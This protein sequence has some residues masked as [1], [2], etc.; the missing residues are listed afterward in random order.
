MPKASFKKT[1]TMDESTVT[2]KEPTPTPTVNINTETAGQM[3]PVSTATT[4]QGELIET[5]SQL[6]S[7]FSL[8]EKAAGLVARFTEVADK[9][10]EVVEQEMSALMSGEMTVDQLAE[11]Y[12]EKNLAEADALK[13]Q[14]QRVMNSMEVEIAKT[15]TERK[16]IEVQKE[17]AFT[18]LA[19]LKAAFQIQAESE[20][21]ADARDEALYQSDKR[22]QNN[23]TRN[24][25]IEYRIGWNELDAADKA[26]K[27]SHKQQ[28]NSFESAFR[29]AIRRG[30][31]ARLQVRQFQTDRQVT[32]AQRIMGKIEQKSK[33]RNK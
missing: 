6:G 21:V 5:R 18:A 2:V 19:G 8:V 15:Q 29:A 26:D 24:Q 14:L 16:G 32:A 30:A 3:V 25:D 20:K 17:K 12:G 23:V 22:S 1:H 7:S 33:Q 28:M 10:I 11:K 31:E 4:V 27:L 9:R 13:A